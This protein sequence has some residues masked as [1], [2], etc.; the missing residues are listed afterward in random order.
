MQSI[1]YC[2][3]EAYLCEVYFLQTM[4]D[5]V[6]TISSY[7]MVYEIVLLWEMIFIADETLDRGKY[8]LS[9][10]MDISFQ[11]ENGIYSL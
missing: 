5:V 4:R 9:Y 2:I 1:S 8:N 7:Y 11:K 10:T 3:G 6:W